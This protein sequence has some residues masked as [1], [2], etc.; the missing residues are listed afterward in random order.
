[1]S[2]SAFCER[3]VDEPDMGQSSPIPVQLDR[4]S[5]SDIAGC[6]IPF[7]TIEAPAAGEL[8]QSVYLCAGWNLLVEIGMT[9]EIDL[10]KSERA[11]KVGNELVGA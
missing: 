5:L 1:M 3:L 10:D 4:M 2:Y 11:R 6:D 7:G 9:F 8:A